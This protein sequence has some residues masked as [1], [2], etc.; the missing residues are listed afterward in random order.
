[1]IDRCCISI[2]EKCNLRCRYC[3][4]STEGR[5]SRD[6]TEDEIGSVISAIRGYVSA[7]DIQFKVGIVGGGEPLLRF[8]MLKHIVEELGADSRIRMYTISNG[9]GVDDK[10]LEFL[11]ENR[12]SI[13]YSVSLDGGE[14]L[15]DMNRIDRSGRGTFSAVMGTIQRYEILFG[16]KPS[17]NCTITPAHLAE[18]E[19]VIRFFSDNGFRKVT[20]SR[21][22]DSEDKVLST[23]FD[24]F[25][26]KASG[27]LEIRQLRKNRTYDCT[28][29]GALCGVGRTN[30][31]FASGLAYPCAR[32]AGMERY[33]IGSVDDSL[34][35]I[36]ANLKQ[37]SPCDDGQCYY[38]QYVK[39]GGLQ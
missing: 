24:E 15:H 29:Y 9:V 36:E 2:T 7:H 18:G 37:I 38:D 5:R 4:F 26:E 14:T 3:H 6:M 39:I 32:F 13:E 19:K 34:D 30:I 16:H 27:Y 12:D 31:Y 20:F 35:A 28:Q 23:E 21:L 8:D 11:W 33:C 17:V 1:M 22:F 25:L 10:K